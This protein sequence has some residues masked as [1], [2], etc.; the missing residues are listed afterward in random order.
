VELKIVLES[1]GSE[2]EAE[3]EEDESAFSKRS[4]PAAYP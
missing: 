1:N 3:N 2:D 4:T